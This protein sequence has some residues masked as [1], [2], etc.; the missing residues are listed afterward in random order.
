MHEASEPLKGIDD[1]PE[2][3]LEYL[4][5]KDVLNNKNRINIINS[6]VNLIMFR[7]FYYDMKKFEYKEKQM[8]DDIHKFNEINHW[9]SQHRIYL[10]H[11]VLDRFPQPFSMGVVD[12]FDNSK[13]AIEMIEK[14][15]DWSGH[16][17]LLN[18][19]ATIQDRYR[20]KTKGV[21][22]VAIILYSRD[23]LFDICNRIEVGHEMWR[24]MFRWYISG[25]KFP[26]FLF[27][28]LERAILFFYDQNP[29]EMDKFLARM[30]VDT[31]GTLA[32]RIT[33][34]FYTTCAAYTG[35]N[36]VW[37]V[38]K[39]MRYIT[40]TSGFRFLLKHRLP[41]ARPISERQTRTGLTIKRPGWHGGWPNSPKDIIPF[42]KAESC[43]LGFLQSKDRITIGKMSPLR[44]LAIAYVLRKFHKQNRNAEIQKVREVTFDTIEGF[45]KM[46]KTELIASMPTYKTWQFFAREEPVDELKNIS[47][48]GFS[49]KIFEELKKAIMEEDYADAKK[50][51]EEM[52]LPAFNLSVL[53]GSVQAAQQYKLA[54]ERYYNGE[55]DENG[56]E[57]NKKSKSKKVSWHDCAQAIK[58][59]VSEPWCIAGWRGHVLKYPALAAYVHHFPKIERMMEDGLAK[60]RK[61][62]GDRIIDLKATK[63][64]KKKWLQDMNLS[65][66]KIKAFAALIQ[67]EKA[68]EN[69][70]LA[71]LCA[72]APDGSLG[73]E[74]F[75]NAL[76][77]CKNVKTAE[78]CPDCTIKGEEVGL[79]PLW[80]FKKL[81]YND[82]LQYI[83]GEYTGCCQ[84]IEGAGSS[85]VIHS[86]RSMYGATYVIWY[87]NQIVATSWAWRG[88]SGELVFDNIEA[89]NAKGE[90]GSK[91]DPS[92]RVQTAIAILYK[93]AAK[94]IQGRLCVTRVL[95]G[96]NNSDI[97]VSL[98]TNEKTK[99]VRYTKKLATPID[100]KGYR[101][102]KKEQILL[103]G[104]KDKKITIKK[105]KSVDEESDE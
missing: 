45:G 78:A 27:K 21:A 59:P 35:E 44:R 18:E 66:N 57:T 14:G 51:P 4:E 70:R 11:N 12:F 49:K 93:E 39:V 54:Y 38:K 7:K 6:S 20:I 15:W 17:D 82:P 64:D 76:D 48:F 100:Y 81:D 30:R 16:N 84:H 72:N 37:A 99:S 68:K 23:R 101:D 47:A 53:F 28:F 52:I 40:T 89:V 26:A 94:R 55:I 31:I 9:Y 2:K 74:E 98:L 103:L 19:I 34:L 43:G 5:D 63:F 36:R 102:S 85:C 104:W 83:I 60:D 25:Q 41:L 77:E 50:F 33:D 91:K 73:N 96:A 42:L 97:S 80:L 71:E 88:T 3:F 86:G 1:I 92:D 75:E 67:Y 62:G 13:K 56:K 22:K 32:I 58:L 8:R 46:S 90:K 61:I 65:L 29:K 79:D 87:D 24:R 10:K 69:P 95:V 105:Q